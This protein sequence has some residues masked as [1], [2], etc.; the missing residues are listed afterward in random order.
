MVLALTMVA[1]VASGCS[2]SS[3]SSNSTSSVETTSESTGDSTFTMR[4]TEIPDMIPLM[5]QETTASV[6]QAFYDKL[7]EVGSDGDNTYYLAE[8]ATMDDDGVTYTI[9]LRE[10]ATWSDGEKITADD[11]T[12]TMDYYLTGTTTIDSTL[13]S[14]YTYEKVD[15]Y[16]VKVVTDSPASS[17]YTDLGSIFM[18]PAHAFDND[19][20]KIE[21]AACLKSTDLVCSGPYSI[22]EW[23]A[24]ESLV[25]T[26]REDYYRGKAQVE[27][28][29]MVVMQDENSSYVAFEN[30]ELSYVTV[31]TAET[32]EKYQEAGYNTYSFPAGK[33]TYLQINPSAEISESD[34]AR[35]AIS[36]ALNRDEIIST[37]Y[38]SEDL[39]QA[40][41]NCFATTQLY[42]DETLGEYEYNVE[43]AKELAQSSGLADKTLTLLYN[44]ERANVEQIAVTIQQELATIGVNVEVLGLDSTAFFSRV[45][46]RAFYGIDSEDENITNWDIAINGYSGCYGDASTNMM[47][48]MYM[49]SGNIVGASDETM[50]VFMQ[51]Y[52]SADETER[53]TL[54][55]QFQKMIQDENSFIPL[56]ES[57]LVMASQKNVTGL[58]NVKIFP[59]F[60]DYTQL[61]VN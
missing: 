37:A 30:G 31:T 47:T 27:T 46:A 20:T 39:A 60:V 9:K 35:A 15:D 26:A 29:N 44:N 43:K 5:G 49:G 45:F 33:I 4:I 19:I 1:T 48:F 24:G 23:N 56:A 18:L 22:T 8:S 32:L 16:T 54:Y 52:T 28:L 38:G 53:E 2:S 36:L 12:F 58:D 55:K 42:Y 11:L 34:D 41:S 21:G 59:Q 57:K 7:Y 10:N 13:A 14:G 3:S 25:C 61:K 6:M 40:T 51:A 17:F 50:S